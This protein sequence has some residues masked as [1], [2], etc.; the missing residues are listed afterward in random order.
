MGRLD[1]VPFVVDDNNNNTMKTLGATELAHLRGFLREYF[2]LLQ[3]DDAGVLDELH[4]QA[5]ICAEILG[6]VP[7]VGGPNE[8][9]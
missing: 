5:L 2:Y 6:V 3:Y 1:N 8:S 9:D 7:T 4:D